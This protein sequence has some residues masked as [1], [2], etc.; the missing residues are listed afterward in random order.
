MFGRLLGM[1]GN[2]RAAVPYLLTAAKLQPRLPDAHK[3]LANV[4]IELGE[5]EDAR[6]EH[7]EAERLKAFDKPQ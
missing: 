7:A 6:R 1:H 5:E 4:Y 2:P 3:F